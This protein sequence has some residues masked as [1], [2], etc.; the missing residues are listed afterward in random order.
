MSTQDPYEEPAEYP[1]IHRPYA[2]PLRNI[3]LHLYEKTSF[4]CSLSRTA[5]YDDDYIIGDHFLDDLSMTV[6]AL[7]FRVVATDYPYRSP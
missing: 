5:C 1:L 3:S 7:H 6:I 2:I 4:G